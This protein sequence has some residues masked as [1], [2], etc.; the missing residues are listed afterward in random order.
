MPMIFTDRLKEVS[1]VY[2]LNDVIFPMEGRYELTLWAEREL[3]GSTT[4]QLKLK[5]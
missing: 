3:M 1:F 5:R 2:R 4:L